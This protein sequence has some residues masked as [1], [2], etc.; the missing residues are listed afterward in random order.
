MHKIFYFTFCKPCK[1]CAS[2]WVEITFVKK[3]ASG[4]R[5]SYREYGEGRTEQAGFVYLVACAA[6]VLRCQQPQQ[7]AP[8]TKRPHRFAHKDFERVEI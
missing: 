2:F 1:H 3:Q 4:R 6:G 5:N 7:N 8:Q